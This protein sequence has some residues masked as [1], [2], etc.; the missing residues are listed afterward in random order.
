MGKSGLQIASVHDTT[1]VG[2]IN[3]MFL[4]ARVAYTVYHFLCDVNNSSLYRS[5][6]ALND[7][8]AC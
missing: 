6:L 8:S 3:D 7:D 1:Q 4:Q 5:M 2:I